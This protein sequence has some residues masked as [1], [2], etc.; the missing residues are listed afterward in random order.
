LKIESGFIEVETKMTNLIRLFDFKKTPES[1]WVNE[2]GGQE[3][4]PK[5]D[6]KWG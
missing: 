1:F 5:G 4:T 6:P 3:K 2:V